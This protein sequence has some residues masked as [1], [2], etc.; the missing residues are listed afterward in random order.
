M[1]YKRL[2]LLSFYILLNVAMYFQYRSIVVV[3]IIISCYYWSHIL[4]FGNGVDPTF[5]EIS[6]IFSWIF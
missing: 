6:S 2:W 1:L 5:Q 4:W 3:V